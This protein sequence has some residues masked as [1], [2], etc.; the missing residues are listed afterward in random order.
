MGSTSYQGFSGYWPFVEKHEQVPADDPMARAYDETNRRISR[1]WNT[2]PIVVVSNSYQ[3]PADGPWAAHTTVI[4]RDQVVPWKDAGDAEEAIVFASHIM[5]NGLLA[6]G[7]VD[8]LRLMVGPVA[9]GGGTPAFEAPAS[10]T[11]KEIR[12][13]EDSDN[14]LLVYAAAGKS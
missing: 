4:G 9:L 5:W 11:L 10:L 1:N 3:V 13:R 12:R 6:Q 7:L 2:K 14:V 8:E